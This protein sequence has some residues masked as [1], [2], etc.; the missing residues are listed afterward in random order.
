MFIK[1]H[2]IIILRVSENN[3]KNLKFE[4]FILLSKKDE[5]P[6]FSYT[7]QSKKLQWS[8][9]GDLNVLQLKHISSN[10]SVKN[11]IFSFIKFPFLS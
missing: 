9:K 5:Y 3:T 8:Y 6:W 11:Y 1:L 4:I 2:N 10:F 7:Q